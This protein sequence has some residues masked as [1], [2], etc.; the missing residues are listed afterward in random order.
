MNAKKSAILFCGIYKQ[1]E[2][3]TVN[4]IV[5]K[6]GEDKKTHKRVVDELFKKLENTPESKTRAFKSGDAVYVYCI[7]KGHVFICIADSTH[8]TRLCTDMLRDVK[9]SFDPS[10]PTA[11]GSRDLTALIQRYSDPLQVNKTAAIQ[12][13]IDDTRAALEKNIVVLM[14]RGENLEKLEESAIELET[15]AQQFHEGATV[16]KTTLWY[17]NIRVRIML[18]CVVI[19]IIVAALLIGCGITFERCGN[20]PKPGPPPPAPV[21]VNPT[22]PPT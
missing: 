4:K 6:A 19:I 22:A 12:K 3:K 21:Q 5:T 11:F 14:E 9:N 7:D 17:E 13:D 15:G 2:D 16:L 1:S 10:R 8:D 18:I 20:V